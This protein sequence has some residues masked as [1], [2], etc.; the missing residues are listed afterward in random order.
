ME[1]K[2]ILYEKQGEIALATFNRP[3][4]LNAFRASTFQELLQI[5]KDAGSDESLRAL[6]LTGNGRAFTA[7]EDLEELAQL[8]GVRLSTEDIKN[9]LRVLQEITRQIVSLPKVVISAINGIAVG[10]GAE[11]AIAS[12]IRIASE[13]ATIALVE[14]KRALFP[15]NGVHYLLPRLIGH[16]RAMEML[17]TGETID[18]QGALEMGLVSRVVPEGQLVESALEMANTIGANAPITVRLIKETMRQ[19][20]ELDLDSVMQREIDGCM[21]CLA[22]E[23]L[24][25]G[26]RSFQE[27]RKPQYRGM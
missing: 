6:V 26:I 4:R 18:A 17:V 21:Q 10:F 15:T 2:D 25:E 14:A 7:G 3:D 11:V 27:K 5:L 20:H 13:K 8:M 19:A 23:D 24:L 16:G 22:S 12:D 9:Q 1:L